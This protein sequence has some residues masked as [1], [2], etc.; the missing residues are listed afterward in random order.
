MG[1]GGYVY[2]NAVAFPN[3]PPSAGN[4]EKYRALTKLTVAFVDN[5]F[6]GELGLSVTKEEVSTI[7]LWCQ[8][9]AQNCA[10]IPSL[11]DDLL[12]PCL[13]CVDR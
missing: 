11:R 7:L 5:I 8:T 10:P 9:H 6:A 13:C 2:N 3:M 1:R 4:A 12:Q